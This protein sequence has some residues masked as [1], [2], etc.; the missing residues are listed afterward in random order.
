VLVAELAKVIAELGVE[1]GLAFVD[2]VVP[3]EPGDKQK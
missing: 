2:L 1:D 3:V